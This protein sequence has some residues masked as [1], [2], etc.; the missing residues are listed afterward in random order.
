MAHR[1]ASRGVAAGAAATFT[2]G[3]FALLTGGVA[4]AAP[5]SINWAD[6]ATTFT[7]T[8]DNVTPTGGDIVTVTTKWARTDANWEELWWAKDH[9][10]TC[11]T[12]VPGSAKLTD[13]AGVHPIEPYVQTN[14]DNTAVD[15]ATLGYKP[16][17]KRNVDTPV[18]S[19]QYTVG[20]DCARGT[21]LST[22]LSYNGSRGAGTYTTQGPAIT[23]AKNSPTTTLAPVT[24]AREGAATTLT[25]TLAGGGAAGDT[26]E[27]YDGA[28]KIGTGS[29]DANHTATFAWTPNTGGAHTLRAKYLGTAFSNA[30][31]SATQNVTVAAAD[32]ASTTT[33]APVTGAKEGRQATLTATITP[34]NAGGTVEFKDGDTVIGTAAVDTDGVATQPWTPTTAGARVITATYSGH[35][36][37]LG[38]TT[39]QNTTVAAADVASTTTLAPVTGA[40][41]GRQATLTATITPANAGGTV[42]FKDGDTVIGTATVD[43]DGVATQPWTPTT[44]GARVITATYSGHDNV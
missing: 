40:K 33:L 36:N 12:Y 10:A 19:I 35:D 23:V 21:N 27:F 29:L 32:V 28:T 18:L 39:T 17:A 5:G 4:N 2:I 30:S 8:I 6:G 16:L 31:E 14:A 15:F 3:A 1:A 9:H 44:A 37:V 11:L 20:N 22:G 24:G 26:V 41:E 38:S 7:R 13:A 34:A 43:T 25:A 42:E